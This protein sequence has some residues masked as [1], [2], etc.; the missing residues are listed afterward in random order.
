M[1]AISDRDRERLNL[2]SPAANDIGLG[3]IIKGL[4]ESEG[5][6]EA[7][8]LT[9]GGMKVPVNQRL[10]LATDEKWIK[11][12]GHLSDLI[13]L[14]W[15]EREKNDGGAK[16]AM[17]WCDE[18]GDDKAAII[19]HY[20]ANDPSRIDH[21][22]ISI[23]TTMSPTGSY[24]DE[25]FTRF[26]LPFDA[27]V[28]EIQSHDSNMTVV[29]GKL[30]VM[31]GGGTNRDIILGQANSKEI[32]ENQLPDGTPN[33]DKVFTPRWSVRANNSAESTGNAGSDF[34]V[35]RYSDAGAA[36]DTVI[37]AKRSNGHVGVMTN[38]PTAPL[39]VNGNSVRVRT[40]KT[41]ASAT[42]N[43]SA[44]EICWDANYVYVCVAANTW[45]RSPLDTW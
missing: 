16:P 3:D 39:D 21:R 23:E 25:L 14:Q 26:E 12:Q 29:G 24:P 27:D 9:G 37:S 44:G 18:K 35:V 43:G 45:K 40:S 8:E 34:A 7:S 5:A 19:A 10:H 6:F 11:S 17:V 38:S 20:K 2:S 28:C 42:A 1:P 22:H 41:P 32:K 36:L 13:R 15:L 30:R 33:Y 31:G 4:Q